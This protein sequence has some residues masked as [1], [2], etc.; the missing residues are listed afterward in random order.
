MFFFIFRNST[1]ENLFGSKG[2]TYSGYDDISFVPTTAHG[3]IWLYLPLP[4]LDRKLLAVEIDTYIDKLRL[5]HSQIPPQKNFIVFTLTDTFPLQYANDEFSFDQ[6]ICHFNSELFLMSRKY[7]N[8][9]VV[10]IDEFLNHFNKDS[11]I[12]WKYYFISLMVFNPKLAPAFR[13]WFSRRLEEICLVRKKCLILDLDNTLWGGI[14]GEDG[15]DGINIGGDYPG[16]AF[17]YFQEALIE[18]SKNGIILA[19]CSKNN[20]ADVIEAWEKNPYIV[21]KQQYIAAYRI[22]WQNKVDNIKEL[23]EE[24]NIGL[25]SL[26][27]V[28]D[29]PMERGFVK[30]LLPMIVVPEF[31]AQPYELPLFIQN[32]VNDH[33]RIY[34]ITDEDR[35]KTQQ[36]KANADRANERKR[37]SD[38]SDYLAS[39]NIRI[40]LIHANEI[41]IPR[42][43]QMTQKT[44]QFN[45]TTKRYT[46]ADIRGFVQ[47]GWQIYCIDVSDK[48]GDSGITG[49]ILIKMNNDVAIFD[50]FLLSCRILGKGIEEA[51]VLSILNMLREQGIET[52]RASYAPTTKNAQVSD[53][54]DK[55]GFSLVSASETKIYE[56]CIANRVFEVKPYYHIQVK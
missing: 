46:D 17:L 23:A 5:V 51:F 14:L 56:L 6:A 18:L 16:S 19:I 55:L 37:Y 44:N 24:L 40:E 20:E 27:F 8:I 54:Y 34:S 21:L 11:W 33:F 13:K 32:L 31:P 41:N 45:L 29:N 36:Y 26:V 30:Q 38:P 22:N 43:A 3:Y 47:N 50:S 10:N 49:T 7:S 42:I 39:L 35:I 9:K 53:F 4:K 28:D 25:D 1:L 12:D 2:F 15:I 52:V 48:F